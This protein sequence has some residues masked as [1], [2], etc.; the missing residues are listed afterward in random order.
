MLDVRDRA[1]ILSRIQAQARAEDYDLTLH[2]RQEMVSEETGRIRLSEMLEAIARAEVLEN[3]PDF[4][5]GPC[6][7]LYGDTD[8]GRPLHLVCSTSLD[9]L[10]IITVYEPT[11]PAWATPTKRGEKP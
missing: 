3:Y 8:A 2:A 6:C 1:A 9:T 7:L 10:V 4:Y 5:K 11:A